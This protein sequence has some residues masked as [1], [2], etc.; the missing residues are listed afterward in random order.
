MNLRFREIKL[1]KITHPVSGRMKSS[2]QV[3]TFDYSVVLTHSD[4]CCPKGPQLSA[5]QSRDLWPWAGIPG[6]RVHLH[7]EVTRLEQ[8]WVS[9]VASFSPSQNPVASPFDKSLPSHGRL[10]LILHQELTLCIPPFRVIYL[11]KRIRFPDKEKS[12][13]PKWMLHI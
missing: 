3:L 7:L 2:L 6:V 12:V 4:S 13:I 5:V 9:L 1:F 10:D 11:E 8:C